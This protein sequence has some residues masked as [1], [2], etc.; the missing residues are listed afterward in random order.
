MEY[1]VILIQAVIQG[2]TEFIPVSSSGHLSLARH[3]L[4]EDN[5]F[6][7]EGMTTIMALHAGTLV[8]IFVA[9]RKEIVGI[10]REFFLT[11]GDLLRLRGDNLRLSNMND[12]RKMLFMVMIGTALLFP[13]VL[14]KDFFTAPVDDGS[15]V[16]EGVAFVFTAILL[17]FADSCVKGVKTP[18]DMSVKD[19]LTV[20]FFQV[21]ALFPGVSRSGSTISAGLFRG[22]S[23]KTA[24]TYSFLLGVPAIL[25]GTVLEVVEF[26]QA[27]A[28]G[29]A[30]PINWFAL[31]LGFV[32]AAITG[33]CAIK[34][35]KFIVKHEKFK[36][37]AI[38]VMTL[39]VLCIIL[40]TFEHITGIRLSI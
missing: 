36:I 13:A 9:F 26:A 1:I 12:E 17:F 38:Y 40:G 30:E 16:F 10:I 3:I 5:E 23:R 14:F 27:S 39:G 34:L 20:G 15:I 18:K 31:S 35:V 7:T 25:G 28:A 6:L 8:S 37:F 21:I 22:L 32:V 29:T 24:V 4:G 33:L 19:A 11:L 2:L